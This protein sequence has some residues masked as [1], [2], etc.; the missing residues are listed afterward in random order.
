[1]PK[2]TFF[3]KKKSKID[4]ENA[5]KE[6]LPSPLLS[7][8]HAPDVPRDPA[9][10]PTWEANHLATTCCTDDGDTSASKI[11]EQTTS[12]S[13]KPSLATLSSIPIHILGKQHSTS[14]SLHGPP[15][16]SKDTF[17]PSLCSVHHHPCKNLLAVKYGLHIPYSFQWKSDLPN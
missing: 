9:H 11:E 12:I 10:F 14:Q 8:P 4:L 15:P 7:V 17:F 13:N 3:F 6:A 2:S 1:M 16:L 5:G